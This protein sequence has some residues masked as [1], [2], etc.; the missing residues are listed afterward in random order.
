M[1]AFWVFL[2]TFR[3]SGSTELLNLHPAISAEARSP[4]RTIFYGEPD[5]IWQ[6][7]TSISL[8][9]LRPQIITIFTC[10]QARLLVTLPRI[11]QLTR[12]GHRCYCNSL[13]HSQR[14]TTM[15]LVSL[16]KATDHVGAMQLYS[17]S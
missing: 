12:G 5:P 3:A 7:V 1:K 15:V 11:P 17:H 14:A 10:M 9:S 16:K 2:G 4:M 13:N 8:C 6:I